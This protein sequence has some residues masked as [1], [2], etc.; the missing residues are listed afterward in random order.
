MAGEL[1]LTLS[2]DEADAERIDSLTSLLKA[3]LFE[4]DVDDVT[5]LRTGEA[6][7]PGARVVDVAAVGGLLVTLGHS[8]QSLPSVIGAIRAWLA[9]GHGPKRTVRVEIGGDV[10]ELSEASVAD[11]DRLIDLFVSKH[12]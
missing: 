6:P 7:P 12:A 5:A 9:R 1:R 11:Q 4:L 2:E 10:L 3:D 8:A